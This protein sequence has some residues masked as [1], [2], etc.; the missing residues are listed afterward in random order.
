M[1]RPEIASGLDEG[2]AP[3]TGTSRSLL[4]RV[5]TA[6]ASAWEQL[7]SLYAPLVYHWCRPFSLQEADLADIVQEVFKAVAAN[8]AL[9]RKEKASDTFR[10]WLRTITRNKAHDFLRRRGR[11]PTG[12]GGTDAQWRLTQIAQPDPR[13]KDCDDQ[14]VQGGF[15]RRVLELIRQEFEERTWQAFWKT[16]V[17]GQSAR[18]A[19]A[20]LSMTSGAVRVA[21]CRVLQR[22]R[23][24]LRD[25]GE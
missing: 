25:L 17:E 13:E 22:L 19:G 3:G 8:I 16:T 23:L 10:G 2:S 18:D 15:Y 20:E 1:Q 7:V 14:Q 21:K 6:E 12:A 9:F 11:E 24:E 5:R 4:E